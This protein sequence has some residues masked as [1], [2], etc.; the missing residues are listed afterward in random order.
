M[1]SAFLQIKEVVTL[2]DSQ[3]TT[4]TRLISYLLIRHSRGKNLWN[5]NKRMDFLFLS[6]DKTFNGE[7][8]LEKDEE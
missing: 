5:P 1:N 6:F 4:G 3:R 8:V 2:E 7:L